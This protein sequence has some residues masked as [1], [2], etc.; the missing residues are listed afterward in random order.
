MVLV[1]GDGGVRSSNRLEGGSKKG[2]S[3][4]AAVTLL[5]PSLTGILSLGCIPETGVW[6]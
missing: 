1:V 3:R 2:R 6:S 5:D 4:E